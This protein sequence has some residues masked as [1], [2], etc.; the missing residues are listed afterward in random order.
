MTAQAAQAHDQWL[1]P[2]ATQVVL[3]TNPERPAYVTVDGGISNSLFYPDHFPLNLSGL[4]I[5]APDGTKAEP[6]NAHTGK[7]RSVFDLKVT[8]TGTYRISV[9]SQ[10][11]F[12]AFKVNGEQQRVRGT[13]ENIQSQ[14]PAGATDVAIT[15]STSRVETFV[16]AGAPSELKPLGSGLELLP[17]QPVTDFVADEPG[18]FR[19][20]VEGKPVAGVTVKVTPGGVRYRGELGDKT[21]T[22]DANGEVAVALP[23][24]G[25]YWINASYAPAGEARR[26]SYSATFEALPY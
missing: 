18:R 21:Y 5:T 11:A 12:A 15:Y 6:E 23:F 8:Q 19:V 17:L 2:S 1:L 10:G 24:A 7:L 13:A 25:A 16:T 20:L 3:S 22:S 14:V 4:S 26:L 9:V